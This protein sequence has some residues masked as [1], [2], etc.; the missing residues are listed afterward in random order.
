L[1]ANDFPCFP[2]KNSLLSA[3]KFPVLLAT[4]SIEESRNLFV[5]LAYSRAILRPKSL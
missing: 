3:E 2:Q 4:N 1:D 5:F